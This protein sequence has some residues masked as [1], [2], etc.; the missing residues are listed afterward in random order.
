QPITAAPAANPSIDSIN[1]IAALDNGA[2]RAHPIKTAT[3]I[4]IIKG[5]CSVDQLIISPNQVMNWST[6]SEEHTSEL[7]S[8]FDLVCRLTLEKKNL[9]EEI[10][11]RI[12][13]IYPLRE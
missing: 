5:L 10:E 13:H 1:A 2:V 11:N 9:I 12:S 4:P 7:Q 8:R 6:R 3:I